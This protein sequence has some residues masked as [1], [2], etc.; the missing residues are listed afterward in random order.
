MKTTVKVII[1]L[2]LFP[3]VISIAVM[4]QLPNKFNYQ[5]VV[6]NNGLIITSGS[7]SLRLTVTDGNGGPA[8]Y[9]ETHLVTPNS[10][11]IVSLEVGGGTVVSGSFASI[12]WKTGNK[13]LQVDLDPTGGSNYTS[14]GSSE[15]LSV[16]FSLYT[17][18]G[19]NELN[20]VNTS[21]ASGG[22]ILQYNGSYWVPG[23]DA[24]TTYTAG[25]GININGTTI[26]NT[27]DTDP[28]DDITTITGAGGDL[29]GTYPNPGVKAIRGINVSTQVP[30]NGQ[31]L[32]YNG[33]QWAPGNDQNT[34][35]SQ[36]TGILIT[37]NTISNTV[38]GLN[39][40][41]DVNTTGA[42]SGEVLKF[43][44]TNWVPATDNT[45]SS[46]GGVN[47]TPRLS[48]DGTSGSPLDI[49]QQG[50]ANGDL[51]QWNGTS[52]SPA[53]AGSIGG[54]WNYSNGSD[55]VN[56]NNGHVEIQNGNLS[57]N[58]NELRLRGTSDPNHTLKYDPLINGPK[59][60]GFA[61]GALG[62]SNGNNSLIWF[63]N[64]NIQATSSLE[65]DHAALNNGSWGNCLAF[66]AGSGE[67]IGSNRD[68][69]SNAINKFGIDFYTNSQKQLSIT[70]SGNTGIG[71]STPGRKL[72]VSGDAQAN[73][74][75]IPTGVATSGVNFRV[76][77]FKQW[78]ET[79]SNGNNTTEKFHLTQEGKP[80]IG[81]TI[82][83][84]IL[85]AKHF[86]NSGPLLTGGTYVGIGTSDP[87]A[88]LNVVADEASGY[89]AKF[90]NQATGSGAHGIA[91]KINN[92]HTNRNNNFVTFINGQDNV[93]GRIEGF[94]D[95]N[96]DWSP[97][98]NLP[99]WNF[100]GAFYIDLNPNSGGTQWFYPP[101]I[102]STSTLNLNCSP[103]PWGPDPTVHF[104]APPGYSS[105]DL[106]IPS[107]SM[108]LSSGQLNWNAG[109]IDP[110]KIFANPPVSVSPITLPNQNPAF[111][112]DLENLI[113]WGI[114]NGVT[115]YSA[116]DPWNLA[117]A[118]LKTAAIKIM[119]DE[120]VTYGSKGADYAEYLEKENP[121]DDMRFGE[122]VGVKNGK[123]SRNTAGAD[124]IMVISH[125][126]I[127]LGN[128]PP[129]G[130]E[131]EYEKV[132]F[133]G[134]VHTIVR[135]SVCAGDYIVASRKNDGTAVAITETELT[136]ENLGQVIGR[137]W[138][139]SENDILSFVN[140]AVGVK[141]NEWIEIFKQQE[142]KS[143]SIENKLNELLL[144]LT[145]IKARLGMEN[146]ISAS[147]SINK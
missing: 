46:S 52:W 114:E 75:F 6:S 70:N 30:S 3:M 77:N 132:G 112:N 33:T 133:M 83:Y 102:N 34:T 111:Y 145:M 107:L 119:N 105:Q 63:D 113:Q 5:A 122:V 13:W 19:I 24:N 101:S 21:G 1:F 92:T 32:K 124:A 65:I 20:D 66:G 142:T 106:C 44:G 38:T 8:L 16:P 129:T 103:L 29:S 109:G 40:L 2:F 104:P 118:G 93:T 125:K 43:N 139:D 141:T 120:G 68:T 134:Q 23:T 12:T 144:D 7:V 90:E 147:A 55:I 146:P 71:T 117:I 91:I 61:G 127:V 28:T 41:S 89:V 100:P 4:A 64:G 9:Q 26:S 48:G 72:E 76:S 54:F 31:I 11:G 27:G 137:A 136:I 14:M 140:T 53:S 15:L 121:T 81:P 62:T 110:T 131:N 25:N 37:G 49:A 87:S 78:T 126:P 58:D 36:G 88:P 115:A 135:G 45:S 74:L 94:D 143:A 56:N 22:D 130:R 73:A 51:L 60:S 79:S 82:S 35:Y 84:N 98:P 39:N 17:D 47:V 67:G 128:T 18:L 97:L 85:T 42:A 86:I 123:I 96:G 108:Q 69:S 10:F 138:E 116:F 57:I 95:Q 99:T 59:L 50:A 80:I